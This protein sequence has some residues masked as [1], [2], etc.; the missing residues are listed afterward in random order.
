MRKVAM[1]AEGADR[2]REGQGQEFVSLRNRH[3]T[4]KA[5]AELR[6]SGFTVRDVAELLGVTPSRV[7]QI[8]QNSLGSAT[9]RHP[10]AIR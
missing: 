2:V 1:E 8:E 6:A 3:L 5:V 7:S 4:P 9:Y 10:S